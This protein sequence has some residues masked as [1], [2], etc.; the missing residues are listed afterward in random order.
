MQT[1][2]EWIT[3]PEYRE[4]VEIMQKAQEE[5]MKDLEDNLSQDMVADIREWRV[6]N[7]PDDQTTHS[8]R[9]VARLFAE[10]YPEFS[11]NHSIQAGNQICGMQLCDAAMKLLNQK[12]EEGWN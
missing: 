11:D 6:G 4:L 5:Q 1:F 3:S 10:K 12:P 7:G 8:W 2:K 9:G